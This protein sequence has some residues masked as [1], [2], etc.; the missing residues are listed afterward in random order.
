MANEATL[1]VETGKPI[2]FTVT[3]ATGIEK[4]TLLV[5]TDLMT[6]AAAS[7]TEGAIPAGIAACE[8]IASDGVTKLAV[9]REGIFK[10]TASGS[11]AVGDPVCL[12]ATANKVCKAATNE[13]DILG[14]A[15]ETASAGE[16]FLMELRP[17]AM[18][19]A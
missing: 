9:Y 16:T 6:A 19:L 18:S 5:M 8:K 13:E 10:V 11:I 1:V 12:S 14:I 15:F 7:T 2:N 3:N 17:T 4:G